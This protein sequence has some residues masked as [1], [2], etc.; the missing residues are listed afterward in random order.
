MSLIDALFLVLAC[1]LC[2][3]MSFGASITL[4]FIRN[5]KGLYFSSKV[6]ASSAFIAVMCFAAVQYVP[7]GPFV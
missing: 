2:L 6:R 7:N 1:A 5:G 3:C 4:G